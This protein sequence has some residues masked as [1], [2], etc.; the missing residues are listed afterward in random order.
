M[1]AD[2]LGQ[3]EQAL[4]DV[5]RVALS[6]DADGV[7]QLGRRLARRPPAD[8]LHPLALKEMLFSLMAAAPQPDISPLRGQVAASDEMSWVQHP[9]GVAPPV[10]TPD[11][12]EAVSLIIAEHSLPERL[13]EF[14][15]APS[16]AILFTGPPGVGKTLTASYVASELHL[17]L[18]TLNLAS[19]MSSLMGQTGKNLQDVLARAASEAC[20]VFLDEFDAIAKR[21]VDASDVGEVKRLVNVV[22]QQLDQWPPGGLLVAATNHPQLL[23]PAVHRRFDSSIDFTLPGFDE[24]VRFLESSNI[25]A[26]RESDNAALQIV[27]LISDGW[28]LADLK[29][30]TNHAARTA[31]MGSPEGHVDITDA[32]L[33]SA[34]LHA[35]NWSA[36]SVEKRSELSRLAAQRLGWSQ[37]RIADWLGVSHVTIGKDVKRAGGERD[38]RREGEA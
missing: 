21:R 5:T 12:R 19:L 20:I 18:I 6:G 31:V 33:R 25:T 24:R 34:Q 37:R 38:G 8:A 1:G 22:L 26:L 13:Q 11:V 15:L 16:R 2:E 29:S 30:W 23:D 3:L 35:R 7:R 10:L 14:G 27:A 4:V 17:P 32:L 36:K 9:S 28:S